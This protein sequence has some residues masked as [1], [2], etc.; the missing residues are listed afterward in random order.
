MELSKLSLKE[1][2]T[3]QQQIEQQ[4]LISKDEEIAKA[5][6]QILAIAQ[7]V[8]IPLKDL[9]GT[10]RLAKVGAVKNKVAARYCHPQDQ[11]LKWTGRGRQPKW[12]SEWVGSGKPLDALL[13]KSE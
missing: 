12:V 11:N 9:M 10:Q 3:L 7:D 4:I 2:R 13:I 1:L 8:G 5:R 6:E